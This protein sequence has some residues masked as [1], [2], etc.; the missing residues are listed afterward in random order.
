MTTTKDSNP[1]DIA[2]SQKVPYD[3]LP[4]E[5]I[6]EIAVALYEGK[7]KYA[8]FNWATAGVQSGVYI[9]AAMRHLSTWQMGENWD[10]DSAG[11]SHITKAIASLVVLRDGMIRGNFIDTR[12][13]E[14]REFNSKLAKVVQTLNEMYPDAPPPVL[15]SQ[16]EVSVYN[17]IQ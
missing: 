3:V 15:A 17:A 8:G 5:V 16:A 13:P 9:S 6:A 4:W 2:G 11:L 1:K 10:S 12:P 7:R 14:C